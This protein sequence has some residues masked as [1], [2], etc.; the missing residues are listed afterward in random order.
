MSQRL[1]DNNPANLTATWDQVKTKRNELRESPITLDDGRTFDSDT[2][3]FILFEDSISEFAFLDG[4]DVD[5]KL[6]WKMSNNN[7]TPCSQQDLID[8][9]AELRRK[10]AVRASTLQAQAEILFATSASVGD[11]ENSTNW[12]I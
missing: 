1:I 3:S 6:P 4:K 9:L 11:I 7:Y 2:D 12:A 5:G 8:I 10:R